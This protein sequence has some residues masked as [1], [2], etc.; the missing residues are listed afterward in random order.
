MLH[1]FDPAIPMG[2]V[3]NSGIG[4]GYG[5]YGFLELTNARAIVYQS[6]EVPNDEFFKPPYE[7]KAEIILGGLK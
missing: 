2:G 1:A 5:K 7:G 6:P 4:K 3:N